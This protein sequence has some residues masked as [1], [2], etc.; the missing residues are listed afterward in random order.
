MHFANALDAFNSA[1]NWV[2]ENEEPADAVYSETPRQHSVW[3]VSESLIDNPSE[4]VRWSAI[5]LVEYAGG[6]LREISLVVRRLLWMLS[7]DPNAFNRISALQ[8]LEE[9]LQRTEMD[10][11]DPAVYY[12]ETDP[13]EGVAAERRFRDAHEKLID[14][15]ERP[16]R[17][18]LSDAQRADYLATLEV[19][20]ARPLPRLQWQR[21]QLRI[22]WG[23]LSV[24]SDPE[25]R[26]AGYEAL[27]WSLRSAMC[28]GL[29][30]ALVPQD[31]SAADLPDVRNRA[32]LLYRRV[33][34]IAALPFLLRFLARPQLVAAEQRYDP[35]PEVRRVL[36]RMCA[37]LKYEHA[38]QSFEGGPMP[39]E[40]LYET[41]ADD[42]DA[43][44]RRVAL[45]GLARC[46]SGEQEGGR[47]SL[48]FDWA[49]EWWVEFVAQR[50][51][52]R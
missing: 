6:D 3:G 35:D 51:R 41:A 43:G 31:R 15:F 16:G 27:R 26:A 4:F 7:R 13:R 8:G 47:I 34:G 24:E 20:A 25:V 37:Q 38:I 11:L 14:L 45:E 18:A 30:A 1:A 19:Y 48:E 28:N 9:I 2:D 32:L 17:P 22:L 52:I 36:V 46:I 42:E 23:V 29:R 33:S 40:F 50:D 39:I 21:L 12:Q 10:L 5:D 44:L 49:R